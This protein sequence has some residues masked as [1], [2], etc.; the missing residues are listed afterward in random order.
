MKAGQWRW[1][2][3]VRSLCQWDGAAT[4]M[5]PRSRRQPTGENPF[6]T[7]PPKCVF[8]ARSLHVIEEGKGKK[9][10]THISLWDRMADK[11]P[12]F[13]F[14]G[15]DDAF[16][17]ALPHPVVRSGANSQICHLM[18]QLYSHMAGPAAPPL[19]FLPRYMIFQ[20]RRSQ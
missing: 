20:G 5:M 14:G 19:G 15:A 12:F 8:K 3:D 16:T 11:K 2:V 9:K 6:R 13:F 1:V 7:L 10:D 4:V 17:P 18:W